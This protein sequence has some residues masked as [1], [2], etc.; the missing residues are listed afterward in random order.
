MYPKGYHCV[1]W[2]WRN[3]ANCWSNSWI[4]ETS[5]PRARTVSRSKSAFLGAWPTPRYTKNQMSTF[6]YFCTP[7]SSKIRTKPWRK[8]GWNPVGDQIWEQRITSFH[9][10]D[11]KK[12]ISMNFS[13]QNQD[14]FPPHDLRA[15]PALLVRARSHTSSSWIWMGSLAAVS[16]ARL[17]SSPGSSQVR[18]GK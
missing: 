4:P 10:K 13:F 1:L 15:V 7:K 5:Q 17:E 8:T 11:V 3:E 16:L 18:D 2:L 14:C 6:I 9:T 12:W